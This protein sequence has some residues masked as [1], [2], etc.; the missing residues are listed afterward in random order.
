M[1]SVASFPFAM[2]ACQPG[3]GRSSADAGP[4]ISRTQ[5]EDLAL[6]RTGGLRAQ[7]SRLETGTWSEYWMVEVLLEPRG[8]LAQVAIDSRSGR[9]LSVER[10]TPP[11]EDDAG[12]SR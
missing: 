3:A 1:A 5:A 10:R 7:D 2:A 9:I 6:R 8:S 12:R 4:S 11:E